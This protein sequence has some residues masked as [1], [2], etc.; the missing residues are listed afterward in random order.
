MAAANYGDQL[1]G[2]CAARRASCGSAGSPV[3]PKATVDPPLLRRTCRDWHLGK[4]PLGHAMADLEESWRILGVLKICLARL[5]LSWEDDSLANWALET[6]R[7][8]CANVM[9]SCGSQLWDQRQNVWQPSRG[10]GRSGARGRAAPRQTRGSQS[11][12]WRAGGPV[13]ASACRVTWH[14]LAI[15][16]DGQVMSGHRSP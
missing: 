10:A 11:S 5:K 2:R 16:Q 8:A 15:G 9:M 6:S 14:D 3:A 1:W 13:G 12:S 4:F 7:N